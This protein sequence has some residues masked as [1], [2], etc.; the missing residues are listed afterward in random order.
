MREESVF[1]VGGHWAEAGDEND[2][3][4]RVI[5]CD[6]SMISESP[7]LSFTLVR[8]DSW[9]IEEIR[10]AC[11]K[12]KRGERASVRGSTTSCNGSRRPRRINFSD[13]QCE[14]Y[15][16]NSSTTDFGQDS[17]TEAE[18]LPARIVFTKKWVPIEQLSDVRSVFFVPRSVIGS[19]FSRHARGEKKYQSGVTF[20]N[21]RTLPWRFDWFEILS[22]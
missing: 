13:R 12:R 20:S 4:P 9:S 18:L 1:P 3:L 10:T 16:R 17:R 7:E 6:L 15:R 22:H 8:F 14:F 11:E 5:E 21:P 19:C 2:G